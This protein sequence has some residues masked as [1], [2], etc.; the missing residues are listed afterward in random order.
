M[1]LEELSILH[2]KF[3]I[4]FTEMLRYEDGTSK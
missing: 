3:Y 1:G 4:K 2:D